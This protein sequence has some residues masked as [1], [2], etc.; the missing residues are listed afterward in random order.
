MI[1]TDC[2]G[3]GIATVKVGGDCCPGDHP[4]GNE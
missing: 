1:S 4:S 2:S 3:L